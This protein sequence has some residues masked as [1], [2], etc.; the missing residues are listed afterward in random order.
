M[1]SALAG[2]GVLVTRPARQAAGLVAQLAALGA[3][4]IVFPAIVILPPSDPATLAR[5]HAAL[6]TYDAA[7]F[8]SANAAEYGAPGAWP[9]Q[10]TAIAT[11]PGSAA[12]LVAVGVA[13]VRIPD[14][15]FDS[16]G[17]LALPELRQVQ[18]KRIAI[19]R[20]VGGRDHLRQ[21]LCARGAHVDYVD[22]YRRARPESGAGG[23][24]EALRAGRVQALTLTSSEGLDNL[25]AVLPDDA[26]AMMR[27]LPAFAPHPRIAA[28]ARALGF[29]AIETPSGDA[30]LLAGLLEWSASRS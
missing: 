6:A 17:L 27:R 24:A 1:V 22:C 16:D 26:G 13:N 19:F 21:A 7:I 28:H 10:V 5:A 29:T 14:T 30:G 12:A 8:V 3:R 18:G 25:C 23:L 11:G 4:P 9:A 20:G 15:T 2:V